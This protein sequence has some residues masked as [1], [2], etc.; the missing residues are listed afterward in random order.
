MP[1][2][3][4]TVA[5]AADKL[6]R[7]RVLGEHRRPEADDSARRGGFRE[8]REQCRAEPLLLEAIADH[9]GN[10]RPRWILRETDKA[11]DAEDS[12]RVRCGGCYEC[13]MVAPVDLHEVPRLR[14][15]QVRLGR[16]KAPIL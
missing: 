7:R 5:E 13:D 15:R 4:R 9:D 10:L 11:C 3:P 14:V 2:A 12:L 16:Q 8:P 1:L 6:A